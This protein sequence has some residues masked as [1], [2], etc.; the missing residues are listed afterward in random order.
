M[1]DSRRARGHGAE[2]PLL[3]RAQRVMLYHYIVGS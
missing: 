3:E 2:L 1:R